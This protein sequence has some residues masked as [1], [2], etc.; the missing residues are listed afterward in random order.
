MTSR[1]TVHL[2]IMHCLCHVF[3]LFNLS[4]D[5]LISDH[6]SNTVSRVLFIALTI[7]SY[8]LVWTLVWQVLNHPQQRNS[9]L[10]IL[11]LISSFLSTDEP[12]EERLTEPLPEANPLPPLVLSWKLFRVSS[13]ALPPFSP[14]IG[15]SS[16]FCRRRRQGS[17]RLMTIAIMAITK[18]P[19]VTAPVTTT[20][21]SFEQPTY[22]QRRKIVTFLRMKAPFLLH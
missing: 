11:L 12:L 22:V 20:V 17:L 19:P 18:R 15:S 14:K 1:E 8:P 9:V 6:Y 2:R 3:C 5:L 7:G 16:S 4:P 10:F 13:T 21:L